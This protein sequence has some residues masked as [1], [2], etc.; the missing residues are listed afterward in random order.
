MLT[1]TQ[2]QHWCASLHLPQE[3]CQVLL[4]PVCKGGDS[5]G[6]E[7]VHLGYEKQPMVSNRSNRPSVG[8]YQRIDSS[9]KARRTSANAGHA[10]HR[11]CHPLSGSDWVSMENAAA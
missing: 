10:K 9:C 2:F 3:T 6:V 11:E 8:L 5:R 4:E 1:A 7:A